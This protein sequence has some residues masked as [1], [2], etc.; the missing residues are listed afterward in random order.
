MGFHFRV[1]FPTIHIKGKAAV[2]IFLSVFIIVGLMVNS[3]YGQMLYEKKNN[4]TDIRQ[5]Q[6]TIVSYESEEY[7]SNASGEYEEMYTYK[8]EYVY[9]D[10]THYVETVLYKKYNVGDEVIVEFSIYNLN[11][12]KII[13]KKATYPILEYLPI[14]IGTTFILIG[15]FGILLQLKKILK[16]NRGEI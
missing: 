12:A 9:N 3:I 15:V 11:T 2:I 1:K 14:V 6:G 4:L 5:V 16:E 13:E 7:F 8:A 10:E